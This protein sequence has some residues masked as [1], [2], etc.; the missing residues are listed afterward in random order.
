[1]RTLTTRLSIGA[2]GLSL[3]AGVNAA[4]AARIL[5]LDAAAPGA[6]PSAGWDDLSGNN[7]DFTNNGATYNA[8]NKSYVF[9]RSESDYLEGSNE[10][11]YDFERTDSFSVVVYYRADLHNDQGSNP[12]I[13]KTS[14]VPDPGGFGYDSYRGYDLNIRH[15]DTS[16]IGLNQGILAHQYGNRIFN[17]VS[18]GGVD[19]SNWHMAVMT[20]DGSSSLSGLSMYLDGAGTSTTYSEDNLSDSILNDGQVQIGRSVF[21][22]F[23][24]EIGI[25]EIWN[26]TLSP[27]AVSTRWNGGSPVRAVPEP[28]ASAVLFAAAACGLLR[29]NGRRRFRA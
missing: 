7:S 19:G 5:Y 22:Y 3:F 21:E 29:R 20:F 18:T 15:G 17:R 14:I 13:S 12:A 8:G 11:L 4:Q 28:A 27:Q 2:L 10:A 1:M 6:N 9:N 24:G 26:E 16:T 23:G 25:V